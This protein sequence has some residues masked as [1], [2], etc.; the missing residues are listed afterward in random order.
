MYSKLSQTSNIFQTQNFLN[1][2]L[3][4]FFSNQNFFGTT[5]FSKKFS[6]PK[7][8]FGLKFLFFEFFFWTQ[9]FFQIWNFFGPKIFW[10]KILLVPKKFLNQNFF[11]P[12]FFQTKLFFRHFRP[13]FFGTKFFL[14]LFSDTK[15]F[16]DLNFFWCKILKPWQAEHFRLSLV[17]K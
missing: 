13:T 10:P 8:Y 1:Q 3:F 16:S 4:N 11:G 9:I 17:Q 6:R 5:I 15:F 2:I 12:K 14:I 7:I